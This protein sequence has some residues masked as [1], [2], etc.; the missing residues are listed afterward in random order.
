LKNLLVIENNKKFYLSA[1]D[2]VVVVNFDLDIP[3]SMECMPNM[4]P[5]HT[6]DKEV[7]AEA[8]FLAQQRKYWPS[9]FI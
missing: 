6:M 5:V 7:L 3:P 4:T 8:Q 9:G 2:Q 1:T